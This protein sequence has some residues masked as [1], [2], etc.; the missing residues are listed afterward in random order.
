MS[1]IILG[2]LRESEDG[3]FSIQL[4]YLGINFN[5]YIKLCLIILEF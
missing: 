5:G 3:L 1:T 2:I 4:N